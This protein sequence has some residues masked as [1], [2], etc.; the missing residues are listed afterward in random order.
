MGRGLRWEWQFRIGESRRIWRGSRGGT[1]DE[2]IVI[3]RRRKRRSS[4]R[5]TVG[6][7]HGSGFDNQS[8]FLLL[9]TS[10]QRGDTHTAVTVFPWIKQPAADNGEIGVIWRRAPFWDRWSLSK[11]EQQKSTATRE[12]LF[13][14]DDDIEDM[15]AAMVH[16]L[17]GTNFLILWEEI[18]VCLGVK[19]SGS[20]FNARLAFDWL[21]L[22]S[23]PAARVQTWNSRP[24]AC[25][26]PECAQFPLY[27]RPNFR[28]CVPSRTLVSP[29]LH[30]SS[31][32]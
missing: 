12:E 18:S 4:W 21:N 7:V 27:L 23:N 30:S 1:G 13:R 6:E 15:E 5:G 8:P 9:I 20:W 19:K 22:T 32:W 14:N 24:T 11:Y 28:A 10:W 31:S 26:L 17:F 2:G 29:A 16:W 25:K 3:R